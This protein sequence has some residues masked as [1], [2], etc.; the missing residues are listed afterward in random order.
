MKSFLFPRL[1]LAC[2]F[3]SCAS[4][5]RAEDPPEPNYVYWAKLVR[6]VDGEHLALDID[7]GF[8]VWTHNQTLAL[9]DAGGANLEPDARAKDNDRIKKLRE[10]LTDATDIVV[11]TTRDREAKPPRYLVTVWADGTN[12]NEELK[13]AFP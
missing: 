3:L 5:L 2:V 6:I 1:A 4:H 7:L 11:R 9:I 8:S 12:V 10:L 13:K